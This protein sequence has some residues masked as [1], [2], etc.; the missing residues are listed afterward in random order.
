MNIGSMLLLCELTAN[1]NATDEPN[2]GVD[3]QSVDNKH[4]SGVYDR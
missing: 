3:E 4:D 2:Q 1:N